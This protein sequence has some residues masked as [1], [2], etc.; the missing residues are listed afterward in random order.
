VAE[1]R[2]FN[3]RAERAE[4]RRC[5]ASKL[6]SSPAQSRKGLPRVTGGVV[7]DVERNWQLAQAPAAGNYF[8]EILALDHHQLNS[9]CS[10]RNS[11]SLTK[12]RGKRAKQY[13]KLMHQYGLTFGFREPY[14]VLLDAEMVQDAVRF[15]MNLILGLERTLHGQVKPSKYF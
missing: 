4:Y 9:Q 12:M 10:P 8:S 7:S 3:H 14:Q 11:S 13:R 2:Q 6:A 5:S 15:K 1:R